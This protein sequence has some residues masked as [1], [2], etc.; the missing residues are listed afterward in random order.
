MLDAGAFE[1]TT[2][3]EESSSVFRRRVSTRRHENVRCLTCCLSFRLIL[4][5]MFRQIVWLTDCSN[6]GMQETPEATLITESQQGGQRAIA[7]LVRRHYPASLQLARGFLRQTEDAQDAVQM[8]YF[9]ALRR[10]ETFRGEASFKTWINRIVVN[11]CLVQLREARRRVTWV[12]LDDFHGTQVPGILASHAPTPE[13]ATWSHEISSAIS[14]ALAK[15]PEHLREAYTLFEISGLSLAEVA[16]ALGLS[17][18]ATKTR[19]FRA[20][21]GIR[22][23]LQPVWSGRRGR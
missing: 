7:E 23:S 1:T 13:K 14:A 15:L 4:M 19:V 10:L 17:V 6:P 2:R 11:C 22:R 9:L 20:R 8:A 12:R 16:S 3:R 21:A 5:A 18:S